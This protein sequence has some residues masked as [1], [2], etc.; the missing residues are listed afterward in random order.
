M[1]QTA[2]QRRAET[3]AKRFMA[4]RNA[5]VRAER[6]SHVPEAVPASE[7]G[8]KRTDQPP[9]MSGGTVGV[10]RKPTAFRART[11][12]GALDPETLE[13][14]RYHVSAGSQSL[15]ALPSGAVAGAARG[16]GKRQRSKFDDVGAYQ[17]AKA[18]LDAEDPKVR[19]AMLHRE[20]HSLRS[21]MRAEG[22]KRREVR[23][24]CAA[25]VREYRTC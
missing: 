2:A 14:R 16:R 24:A 9:T 12:L 10:P 19:A 7:A 8:T 13:P 25:L 17:R 18:R 6:E 20:L 22:R 21:E 15:A 3:R 5:E 1:S 23:A 11:A 4:Q